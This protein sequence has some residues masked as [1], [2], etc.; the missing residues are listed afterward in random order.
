MLDQVPHQVH[1]IRHI[2]SIENFA[3]GI[4]CVCGCR[5]DAGGDVEA[6]AEESGVKGSFASD[7]PVL[8]KRGGRCVQVSGRSGVRLHRNFQ[9]SI[10]SSRPVVTRTRNASTSRTVCQPSCARQNSEYRNWMVCQVSNRVF[11]LDEHLWGEGIE[12]LWPVQSVRFEGVLD[13][14]WTPEMRGCRG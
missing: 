13:R 8:R 12:R 6:G 2:R 4:G 3:F 7:E 1:G 9:S 10:P 11:Q 5:R 14:V